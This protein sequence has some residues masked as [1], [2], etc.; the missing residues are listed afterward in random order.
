MVLAA[1]AAGAMAQEEAPA[2]PTPEAPA[3]PAPENAAAPGGVTISGGAPAATPSGGQGREWTVVPGA[4]ATEE[5]TDNVRSTPTDR[6]SDIISELTP[7]LYVNGDTPRLKATLNY[8]PDFIEHVTATDQ[9]QINQNL[10]GNGTLTAVPNLLFFDANAAMQNA[11]RAG[12]LGFGN[13]VQIPSSLNTQTMAYS[14]SPYMRLHFGDTGDEELRYTYSATNFS[15]NTGPVTSPDTGTSLGSL[16]SSRQNEFLANFVTGPKLG[17]LQ[18]TAENDYVDFQST[19]SLSSRNETAEINGQY[20]ISGPFFALFDAGYDDLEYTQQNPL[21]YKGPQWTVG[22]RFQPRIDRSVS[23]SYGTTQGQ[24]GFTGSV[25]YALTPLTTVTASYSHESTT[26]QQQIL[27]SLAGLT[28]SAPSSAVPSG[29]TTPIQTP[30]QSLTGTSVNQQTGL[31]SALINPNLALQNS[32]ERL[33]TLEATIEMQGGQR[34]T[35]ALNLNRTMATTYTAGTLSQ[36]TTGGIVSW[37]RDMSP[38]MT[39]VLSAGYSET[40]SS[41]AGTGTVATNVGS[42]TLSAGL[43][44][45]VSNRILAAATYSLA[46]QQGGTTGTILVDLVMVSLNVQF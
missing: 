2:G 44:Y 11:S 25:N 22:G 46:R 16:S 34:N 41:A 15:G 30:T 6:Q 12:G 36:T 45:S 37:N 17:P 7:S 4:T 9:N 1:S 24:Y 26:G 42:T 38:L 5:F 32:T 14:G 39:G 19:N 10:T 13:Q 8:T 33:S 27:Q 29:T 43:N 21:D 3:T 20:N 28:S 31:P 18:L 40:S 35:Y 23:L